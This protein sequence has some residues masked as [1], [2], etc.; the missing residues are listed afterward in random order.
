MCTA[1]KRFQGLQADHP[2]TGMFSRCGENSRTKRNETNTGA[3]L[4]VLLNRYRTNVV[5]KQKQNIPKQ[6][7]KNASTK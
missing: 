7:K 5:T 6:I 3:K 4:K 2:D 1:N